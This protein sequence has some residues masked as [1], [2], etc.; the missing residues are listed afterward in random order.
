MDI[1]QEQFP[2]SVVCDPQGD[3]RLIVSGE[4][5]QILVSSVVMR[6][7]S[8]V[9]KAMLGPN[10]KEGNELKSMYVS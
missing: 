6:L 5:R 1:N 2:T 10:F 3:I 7:S 8:K 9:F 4:R